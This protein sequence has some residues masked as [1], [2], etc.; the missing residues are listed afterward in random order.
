MQ[1]IPNAIMSR[2]MERLARSQVPASYHAEYLQWLRYYIDFCT[3]D[4]LP[5]SKATESAYSVRN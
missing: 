2:F 3:R 1:D 5:D 4:P